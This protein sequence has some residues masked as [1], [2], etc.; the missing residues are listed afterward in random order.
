MAEK[1]SRTIPFYTSEYTN[2][3]DQICDTVIEFSIGWTVIKYLQ[4]VEC[5]SEDTNPYTGGEKLNI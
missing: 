4:I 2:Y 1:T 5:L 3:S